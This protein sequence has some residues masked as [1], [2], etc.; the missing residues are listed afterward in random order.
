MGLFPF[1]AINS[2]MLYPPHAS[3]LRSRWPEVPWRGCPSNPHQP[4]CK[5]PD[6]PFRL[7]PPVHY[8]KLARSIPGFLIAPSNPFSGPG[9]LKRSLTVTALRRWMLPTVERGPPA[10]IC[11]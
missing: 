1:A 8:L 7:T 11:V 2:S 10:T 3:V 5:T 4:Q 6:H 9:S